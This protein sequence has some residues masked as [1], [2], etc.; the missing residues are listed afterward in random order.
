MF[1]YLC[2]LGVVYILEEVEKNVNVFYRFIFKF[3]RSVEIL[4]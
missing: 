2:L 3:S 4:C 1:L